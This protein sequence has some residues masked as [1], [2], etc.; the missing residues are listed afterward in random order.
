VRVEGLVTKP[1]RGLRFQ[2]DGGIDSSSLQDSGVG[3][4][5]VWLAFYV[6]IIVASVT[7]NFRSEPM[8]EISASARVR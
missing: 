8:L 7:T 1:N 3:I 4:A 5:M 2:Q 6:L